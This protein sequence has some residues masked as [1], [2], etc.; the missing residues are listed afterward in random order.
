MNNM[1]LHNKPQ[2][3]IS[4]FEITPDMLAKFDKRVAEILWDA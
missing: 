4:N 3:S 2:Q 1:K